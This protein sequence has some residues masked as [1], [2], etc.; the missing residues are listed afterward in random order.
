MTK[1]L[2]KNLLS[3]ALVALAI[4]IAGGSTASANPQGD[5]STTVTPQRNPTQSISTPRSIATTVTEPTNEQVVPAAE[6]T[7][8]KPGEWAYQTL[9]ALS[10]KYSC[11]N[12]PAGDK[13]LSREEFATSL[14][15]C[16]QSMEQLVAR[17]PR[18]LLKK[19]RVAPAPEIIAP[20]VVTPPAA[21][22]ITPPPADVAPVAPPAP[23]EPEVSQQ[24]IDRL[25][26]L[27]EAF[28]SDLQ[29]VDARI[30]ALDKKTAEIKEKSFST[31][32]KLNGEVIFGVSG[33]G[34]VTST[35]AI[36][37]TP[38]TVV[39]GVVVPGKAA[40]PARSATGNVFSDR[41]RLNFDTSFTGK[42][43]L[44]TRL[45]SRNTPNLGSA[46]TGTNMT[47]LGYDGNEDNGTSVSLLQYSF[48]LTPQTKIIAETIGSEFNENMY[49]FNPILTSSGSGSISRYGRYNPIYRLSGDG[50]SLT[51]NHK[52]S[53]ELA[54]A[55]GY[56][57]PGTNAAASTASGSGLFNG[58]NAII[59]QLQF[60]PSQDLNLGLI[61]ARSYSSDGN[62]ITGGT[63]SSAANRPFASAPTTANH[64]SFLASYKLSPSF[65]FSGWAGFTEANRE[66]TAGGRASSS[67]Y[68]VSLAFPD[69]GQKGNNL[70]FILGIPPKLNSRSGTG[71]AVSP[72][73]STSYHLEALYKMK[74]SDN[75]DLT[76]G[77]LL[78]TNPDHR[79]NPTEYVGTVRTT[80]K[81]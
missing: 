2:S 71:L 26:Q 73:S 28:R 29:S 69:L 56:A 65:V 76:P 52:F 39:N 81:F 54:L 44:R 79:A 16:I 15:G 43:K 35:P 51:L 30:E 20:E 38:A 40:V 47:R 10:S 12:A 19:R 53:D 60:T 59:S 22:E 27:I 32:T 34:G 75:I 42:D 7:E 4:W 11:S 62:N 8:I 31:T 14:D 58:S 46:V 41:V 77:L 17:K 9:Q 61:Y 55:L 33:Y 6:A 3:P 13:T 23:V 49:T 5:R 45:Q 64:Y 18:R 24:D 63:G 80:F 70:A 72:D 78:I 37:E 68:A 66:T 57:I 74:L 36:A 48:P 21:P 67:N 25:K 1:L 50:A